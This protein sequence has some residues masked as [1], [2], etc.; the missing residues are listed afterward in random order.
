MELRLA[1]A[2]VKRGLVIGKGLPALQ[3]VA[4]ESEGRKTAARTREERFASERSVVVLGLTHLRRLSGAVLIRVRDLSACDESLLAV[5]A[6]ALSSLPL[7]ITLPVGGRR[8]TP[9][10]NPRDKRC[11]HP[12]NRLPCGEGPRALLLLHC[13]PLPLGGPGGVVDVKSPS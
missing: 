5:G 3:A 7:H 8:H 6:T 12:L 4:Q 9:R 2:V 1:A 10:V 13:G 11:T